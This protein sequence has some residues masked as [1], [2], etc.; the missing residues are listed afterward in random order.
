[1]DINEIF[2]E[3]KALVNRGSRL[4]KLKLA[5][6]WKAKDECDEHKLIRQQYKLSPYDDFSTFQEIKDGV[7]IIK[8]DDFNGTPYWRVANKQRTTCEL[9]ETKDQ[10]IIAGIFG[11]NNRH[12]HTILTLMEV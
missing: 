4:D 6:M 7:A 8:T 12:L 10:A 5:H 3:I 9:Y 1:M 11:K 2:D